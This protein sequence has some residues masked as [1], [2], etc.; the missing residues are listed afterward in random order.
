MFVDVGASKDSYEKPSFSPSLYEMFPEEPFYPGHFIAV[1]NSGSVHVWGDN[2][3][4]QSSIP[5]KLPKVVA[6]AAGDGYS[7]VLTA[8]GHVV[9]W[10]RFNLII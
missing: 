7:S 9:C 5:A 1:D 3:H 2:N 4:G 8:E 10:G 6:V